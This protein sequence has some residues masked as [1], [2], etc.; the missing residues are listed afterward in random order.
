MFVDDFG[1]NVLDFGQFV[2]DYFFGGFDGGGYVMIFQFVEDEW[3][4]QFQGYF[5]WQIVLVQ[6]QGWV[7]GD[8]GMIGVVYVFVE[9]VLMEVILFVFDYVGQ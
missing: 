2:F 5:F 1:E 9:Q 4:E 8:Y 3:F 7:Y 6:V